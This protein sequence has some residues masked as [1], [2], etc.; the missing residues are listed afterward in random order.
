MARLESESVQVGES[1]DTLRERVANSTQIYSS[2]RD[3]HSL[4]AR[5]L[6]LVGDGDYWNTLACFLHGQCSKQ[7]FDE[8]MHHCLRTSETKL[9]HNELIRS[10]LFNAHFAMTAPRDVE[11]PHIECPAAAKRAPAAAP[12]PPARPFITY[13]ASDLRHLPSLNQL[14]ERTRI[15]LDARKVRVESKAMG[16]IFTHLKKYVLRILENSVALLSVKGGKEQKEMRIT[17]TQILHVM[18]TNGELAS[19]VSPAVFTK[20][21]NLLT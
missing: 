9:L 21:S 1:E 19:T 3:C 11:L 16:L 12:A 8:T 7:T 5:L 10:I 6:E 4:K 2:R 17:T 14:S 20:Y 18:A 13:T 15:L